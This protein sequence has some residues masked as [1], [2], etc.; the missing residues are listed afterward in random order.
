MTNHD[1]P[2]RDDTV[3]VVG[4]DEA[5]Y[6]P[7]LGPLVVSAVAFDVPA[8]LFHRDAKGS[9]PDL[10]RLLRASLS[11]RVN[12]RDPRLCVA[13]SKVLFKPADGRGIVLLER[14]VLAFLSQT[15]QMPTT[16]GALIQMTCPDLGPLL[17]DDPC[18]SGEELALPVETSVADIRTQRNALRADLESAGLRFRCVL[19]EVLPV[20]PFNERVEAARNKAVV[21]F[22]LTTR[23]IERV[24]RL[25][26]A[27][28]LSFWVDRQGGRMHY[29]SPLMSAFPDAHLEILAESAE[30]CGYRLSAPEMRRRVHFIKNGE[31][32][33]LPI[34]LASMTS[35]YLRELLMLGFNRFWSSHLP[36]LKPTG[37]YYEDGR[38][39]LKDVGPMM[40]RLKIDPRRVSRLL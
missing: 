4:I 35:K 23:L 31:S 39:F 20:G 17:A 1:G 16:L 33:H 13:D 40:A 18:R 11:R 32:H 25:T 34:A 19:S 24:A 36:D 21:L 28:R 27:R 7:L 37:G 9:P 29:R 30:F 14:A 12:R 3:T 2:G 10:W 8:C 26:G 22:A 6:G 38:R 15:S 5:G